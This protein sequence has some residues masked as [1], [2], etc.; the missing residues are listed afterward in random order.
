MTGQFTLAGTKLRDRTAEATRNERLTGPGY[1]IQFY[2]CGELR[3]KSRLLN[4]RP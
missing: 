3:R 4:Q 1:F 2:T